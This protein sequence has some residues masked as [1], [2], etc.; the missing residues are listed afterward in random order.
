MSR[1]VVGLTVIRLRVAIKGLKGVIPSTIPKEYNKQ[2]ANVQN[3]YCIYIIIVALRANGNEKRERKE[4]AKEKE[5]RKERTE[6][7]DT[8]QLTKININF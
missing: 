5:R 6:E 2:I 3:T 8:K 1:E 7:L 4:K